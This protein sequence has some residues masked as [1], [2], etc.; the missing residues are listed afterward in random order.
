MK[1][2]ADKTPAVYIKT[3][4]AVC[5]TLIRWPLEVILAYF[6]A[7]AITPSPTSW[8]FASIAFAI[9]LAFESTIGSYEAMQFLGRRIKWLRADSVPNAS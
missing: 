8:A 5:I 2:N 4:P 6:I 7:Q 1:R 3:L 9:F